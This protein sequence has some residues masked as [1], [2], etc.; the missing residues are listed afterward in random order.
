MRGDKADWRLFFWGG[1]P[2]TGKNFAC[3]MRGMAD[4]TELL[5]EAETMLRQRF[6]DGKA[7]AGAAA[8]QP[9]TLGSPR[10]ERLVLPDDMRGKM[11]PTKEKY[12]IRENPHLV[13]WEREVRKFLRNLSPEHGHRVSA[14]MIYEWATG[15]NVSAIAV[16]GKKDGSRGGGPTWRSDLRKINKILKFYFGDPYRTWIGGRQVDKAY[17]VKP[18]TYITRR[19]PM[20]IALYLEYV[21]G[22]LNP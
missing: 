1:A 11:P 8:G 21:E 17:K 20:T 14:S 12:V 15:I 6:I 13:M 19:R 16:E 2:V 5:T 22:S 3:T 7:Y 9:S 4:E 18:G 10:I